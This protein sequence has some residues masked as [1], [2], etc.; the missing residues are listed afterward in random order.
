MIADYVSMYLS[1][2]DSEK[3]FQFA[4]AQSIQNNLNLQIVSAK[5]VLLPINSILECFI[6]KVGLL[7]KETDRRLKENTE[8]ASLRDWLLPML[9]NGQVKVGQKEFVYEQTPSYMTAAS[10][11][12]THLNKIGD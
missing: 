12:E 5:T 1:T 11:D 8:L 6:E 3:E 9:M 4:N 2:R 7:R 10:K